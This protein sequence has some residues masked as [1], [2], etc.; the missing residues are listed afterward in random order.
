MGK[1]CKR[2]EW[3]G[4]CKQTSSPGASMS[5]TDRSEESSSASVSSFIAELIHS[6][7]SRTTLLC[8]SATHTIKP[9]DAA[10]LTSAGWLRMLV[11]LKTLRPLDCPCTA[12]DDLPSSLSPTSD[13]D[14]AHS[15]NTTSVTTTG[16][17]LPARRPT[18]IPIYSL[19]PRTS[20]HPRIPSH[21]HTAYTHAC[22]IYTSAPRDVS[23]LITPHSYCL[24]A[25]CTSSLY[26]QSHF[27]VQ[28]Q[29]RFICEISR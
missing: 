21:A 28:V 12:T 22:R 3:Y 18:D 23:A 4:P 9:N 1:L 7:S 26:I 2:D 27:C 10:S 25:Y 14:V 19:L 20:L 16:R 24:K 13:D 6:A 29:A 15:H 5:T 8:S 17:P 11:S